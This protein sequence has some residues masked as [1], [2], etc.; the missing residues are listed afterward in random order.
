MKE[1]IQVCHC[2]RKFKTFVHNCPNTVTVIEIF[3]CPEH[4]D[5]CG[6]CSDT[7]D[8]TDNEEE[9]ENPIN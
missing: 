6:F 9:N 1:K 5:V 4:D 8:E 3:G 2:G 7:E